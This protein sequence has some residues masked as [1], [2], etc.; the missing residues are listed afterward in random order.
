MS[1]LLV[2][3]K[4]IY[5]IKIM[6]IENENSIHVLKTK[7]EIEKWK[8]LGYKIGEKEG[9][10]NKTIEEIN[11]TLQRLTWG[12]YNEIYSKCI[13][14]H[15]VEEKENELVNVILFRELLL[16]KSLV[17]WDLSF[18]DPDTN[19]IK[20][21]PTDDSNLLPAELAEEIVKI[22]E[23]NVS[24][25]EKDLKRLKSAAKAFYSGQKIK[26]LFPSYIYEH[27]IA[28]NYKWDLD[29]IRDIDN[30]DFQVH[31]TLCI[32]AE[33]AEIELRQKLAGMSMGAPAPKGKRVKET[34]LVKF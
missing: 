16:K 11:I 7:K 5:S 1:I 8:R 9:I 23:T 14:N 27:L 4:R 15:I 17:R 22:I 28:K 19:K 20:E 32:A 26:G 33:D 3:N 13:F 25:S 34:Q 6:Y 30:Y 18:I 31:V 2:P 29:K 24:P 21:V 12:E 10:S